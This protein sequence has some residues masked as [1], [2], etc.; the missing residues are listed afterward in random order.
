MKMKRILFLLLTALLI[1]SCSH[2]KNGGNDTSETIT[3]SSDTTID[4]DQTSSNTDAEITT[5]TDTDVT[6][7]EVPYATVEEL[8]TPDPNRSPLVSSNVFATIAKGMSLN[9]VI[10]T[11]GLPQRIRKIVTQVSFSETTSVAISLELPS[12]VYDTIDGKTC[13][14]IIHPYLLIGEQDWRYE[15]YFVGVHDAESTNKT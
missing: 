14:V 8:V 12:L 4:D 2:L 1:S 13:T 7:G 11:A 15:V 9:D 3:T 10:A 5:N 6:T